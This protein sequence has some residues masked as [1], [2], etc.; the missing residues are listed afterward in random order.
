MLTLK[1]HYQTCVSDFSLLLLVQR[2]VEAIVGLRRGRRKCVVVGGWKVVIP[3]RSCSDIVAR[4]GTA[5]A[6]S[7][8]CAGLG[9]CLLLRMAL[10][11]VDQVVPLV[12]L[13]LNGL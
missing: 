6:L 9:C 13:T 4:A 2:R 10:L 12:R 3:A 7:L 5:D 8:V 1:R 11:R